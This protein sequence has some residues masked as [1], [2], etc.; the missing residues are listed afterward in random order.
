MNNWEGWIEEQREIWSGAKQKI[1]NIVKSDLPE[2]EK[3]SR[4]ESF[5]KTLPFGISIENYEISYNSCGY[6]YWATHKKFRNDNFKLRE[7]LDARYEY[8]SGEFEYFCPVC[9]KFAT[10]KNE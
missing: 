5:L 9:G 2:E 10:H 6:P 7:I 4:I 1:I 8:E 3:K